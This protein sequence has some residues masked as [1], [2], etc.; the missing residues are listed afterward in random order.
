M[1]IWDD[2]A[3]IEFSINSLRAAEG[4]TTTSPA[5]ILFIVVSSS[6]LIWGGSITESVYWFFNYMSVYI[7]TI[8]LFIAESIWLF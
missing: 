5:A 8:G 2:P 4:D 3:S 7:F 6:F 1:L